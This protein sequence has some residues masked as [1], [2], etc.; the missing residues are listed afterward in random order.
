MRGRRV[1]KS[2]TAQPAGRRVDFRLEE[3]VADDILL[4]EAHASFGRRRPRLPGARQPSETERRHFDNDAQL[5]RVELRRLDRT[6]NREWS[7]DGIEF[8]RHAARE[9]TRVDEHIPRPIVHSANLQS[10]NQFLRE[11]TLDLDEIGFG[12][13]RAIGM[14]VQPFGFQHVLDFLQ[15]ANRGVVRVAR[16]NQGSMD[17]RQR[18]GRVDAPALPGLPGK[19]AYRIGSVLV[20]SF[21]EIIAEKIVRVGCPGILPGQGIAEI[22]A[23]GRPFAEHRSQLA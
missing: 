7:V 19:C 13:R 5:V 2:R 14:T 21:F 4:G 22:A 3:F 23:E 15:A 17:R 1:R 10:G 20:D 12:R 8:Q 11:F 6:L 16:R 18:P 9:C